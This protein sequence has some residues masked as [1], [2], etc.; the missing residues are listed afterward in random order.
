MKFEPIYEKMAASLSADSR[1]ILRVPS[2][3][4]STSATTPHKSLSDQKERSVGIVDYTGSPLHR[5]SVTSHP[6]DVNKFNVREQHGPPAYVN[7]S[8]EE[9]NLTPVGWQLSSK[10]NAQRNWNSTNPMIPSRLVGDSGRVATYSPMRIHSS[11][12][13][14]HTMG[15]AGHVCNNAL[16]VNMSPSHD[17]SETTKRIFPVSNRGMG[18]RRIVAVSNTKGE[19]YESSNGDEVV[20][21][22]NVKSPSSP[23]ANETSESSVSIELK[24]PRSVLKRKLPMMTS[25][26]EVE[27]VVH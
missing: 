14:R 26:S 16:I 25:S 9:M 23:I 11:R 10:F 22:A 6:A 27:N 15:G 17:S 7:Y 4:S 2:L 3:S 13:R 1:S 8:P 24:V 18:R 19:G 12:G 21:L 5:H 20:M